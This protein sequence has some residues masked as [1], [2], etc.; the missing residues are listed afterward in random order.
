MNKKALIQTGFALVAVAIV[1]A[2][3]VI[4]QSR[5]QDAPADTAL[6]LGP[7]ADGVIQE[8]GLTPEEVE[9]ALRTYPRPGKHDDEFFAFLSGG[10]K[11][12]I[13][14]VGLPSCR[15]LKEIPVYS[16][17][18]WQGWLTGSTESRDIVKEGQFYP[19]DALEWGDLH[20]PKLS[21]KNGTYDGRWIAA[22]DKAGGRIAIVDLRDLKCKQ[23]VKTPNTISDHGNYWTPNSEYFVTSTFFPA[24]QPYG[25]YQPIEQYAEKYRGMITFH[26]FDSEAG[27]IRLNESW[28]IELPPYF[29]DL[30]SAGKKGSY[31]W[32]FTNSINTEMSYGGTLEG[33]PAMEVGA[34]KNEMDYVHV[35]N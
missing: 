3:F 4:R 2:A 35:I 5:F 6:A 10:H 29:Q 23:I 33:R 19:N 26:K 16:A 21:L 24:P 30:I 32:M 1:I 17:D 13:I 9:A 15:I 18:S 12:S 14:L 28:Q 20:H 25:T 22:A 31:G 7:Q 8:R 34:S 27:R 11:G